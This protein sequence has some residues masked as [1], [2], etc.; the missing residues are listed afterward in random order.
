MPSYVKRYWGE[1]RGDEYAA[2][3]PSWWYFEVDSEGWVLRQIEQYGSG[4]RLCYSTER[5]ED[6]FGGIAE[7]PLDL[8]EAGYLAIARQEFESVWG[9][10]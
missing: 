7:K 10:A 6:E 4:V 3:G 8:S 2:W 1:T 5:M 9:G